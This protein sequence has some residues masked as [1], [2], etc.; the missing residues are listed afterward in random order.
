[1]LQVSSI[2][3]TLTPLD[4]HLVFSDSAKLSFFAVQ[5]AA[6]QCEMVEYSSV[7]AEFGVQ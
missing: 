5:I 1:M 4:K 3:K 6:R 2:K 7:A